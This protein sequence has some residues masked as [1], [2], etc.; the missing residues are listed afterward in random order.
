[1]GGK[2]INKLTFGL[3]SGTMEEAFGL[4]NYLQDQVEA[5]K[6]RKK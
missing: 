1:V 6:R 4:L 5:K 3:I 2:W